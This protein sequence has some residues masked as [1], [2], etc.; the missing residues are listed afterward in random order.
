MKKPVYM[1]HHATTPLDPRILEAITPYYLG[2]RSFQE[3]QEAIAASR[4]RIAR[5]IGAQPEEI[6]FTTGATESDNLALKG[7]AYANRDRGDHIITCRIEHKAVLDACGRLEREGFSVT[8]LP[9]DGY[10][11]VDPEAVARAITDRTILIS[12]I[13]GH[14]EIGTINPI[15][16]IG[17]IAQARGILFHSD[18]VQT[19]GK[20]PMNA[21]AL[22][23]DLL[24]V[25][26]HKMYGPK[27][28]GALYVRRGSPPLRIT[29]ILGEESVA[30]VPGI[31][32]LGLACELCEAVMHDEAG[33][34]ATLRDRLYQGLRDRV[35]DI[36]L[37][38]H[39]T[40]R[41][42]GNLNVCFAYIE[43]G[44]LLLSL[45]DIAVSSGSACTSRTTIDPSYVLLALGRDETLAQSAIRF[46]LGRGNTEEEVDYAI[47]TI[48]QEARKLR[49]LSGH[50]RMRHARQPEPAA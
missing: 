15:R 30:N 49:S 3:E 2:E 35:D 42:P 43:G 27:G 47:E 40:Q 24:S 25:S 6:R 7:V 37:N 44:S 5:L 33:R 12:I 39:P 18:A 36:C 28:V 16:E 8:Y 14:N 31:V 26:A 10:G 45:R 46:G 32:G 50:Y 23:V 38:G 19:T 17:Q 4:R 41:L 20:I 21:E 11:M 22:G 13:H 1:D 9:V 29:P 48:A 34:L